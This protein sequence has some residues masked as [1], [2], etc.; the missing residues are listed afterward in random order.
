MFNPLPQYFFERSAL[1]VAPALLGKLLIHHTDEGLSAGYIV[2]TEA[3][4]GPE[5]R[6]AHS[7]GNRRT[8]RTEVMFGEAGYAYTHVMHTHCLI[9]VVSGEIEQPQGV[10]I[11]AIEPVTGQ[12][13]MQKRRG[14][15]I[16]GINLTNGPGK[17]CKALG[18]TMQ[19]YAHPLW[20]LPLYIAEGKEITGI[21][22][23]PRIGIDNAGEATQYPWRFWEEHNPYVSRG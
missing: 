14:E 15:H 17:L 9:N 11:R 4:I 7:Y 19:Y 12:E 16:K 6:A 3:Y 23:G 22:Q 1:E 21:R 18:I 20:K 10:L 8:V 2:E 5:D 13:L